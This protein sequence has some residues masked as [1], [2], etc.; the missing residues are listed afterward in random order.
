MKQIN[1]SSIAKVLGLGVVLSTPLIFMTSC[2]ATTVGTPL[3]AKIMV[4]NANINDVA[5]FTSAP[6]KAAVSLAAQIAVPAI[7]LNNSPGLPN[8]VMNSSDATAN[9]FYYFMTSSYISGSGPF[10]DTDKAI[11]LALESINVNANIDSVKKAPEASAA[12][13][14]GNFSITNVQMKYVFYNRYTKATITDLNTIKSD[15]TYWNDQGSFIKSDFNNHI[16]N[17]KSSFTVTIPLSATYNLEHKKDVAD[18]TIQ[19]SS[20]WSFS[21]TGSLV[22]DPISFA[23]NGINT[24][25]QNLSLAASNL[26]TAKYNENSQWI[27]DTTAQ[28]KGLISTIA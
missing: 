20:S 2:S 1:K 26:L 6:V 22:K 13:S 7:T 21:G 3:Q 14:T 24:F 16:N 19:D 15:L 23:S 18:W 12:D 4:N 8:A 25:V 28:Y 11:G 5:D 27:K 9:A 17:V 10:I